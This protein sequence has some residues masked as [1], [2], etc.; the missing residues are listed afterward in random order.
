MIGT[1]GNSSLIIALLLNF[2]LLFSYSLNFF[3]KK[4][5]FQKVRYLNFLVT[6]FVFLAFILLLWSFAISDFSNTAVYQNS[7]SQKPLFY[8]ISGSWGNHEGSMVLFILILAIF[9][10]LFSFSG[11]RDNL[12]YLTIFFQNILILF[13]LIFLIFTSNPFDVI[14]PTPAEGLGLNPILQDPLLSIH[15]PFLY[16]GYVGFSIIFSFALAGLY[17]E[18][19]T[20]LWSK[21]ASLWIVIAWTFLTVGIGLGSIWAYYELG[22]GGFWFWDPVENASLVPWLASTALLHSNITSMKT[23][24][25]FSWTALLAILT[26]TTSLLG[27]FL[28]RSGIL[29]SVHAF[30][31]DPDRGLYILAVIMIISFFA[32]LIFILK[33][34]KSPMPNVL[35]FWSRGSFI[36]IN[37]CF[38]IFFLVVVMVGTLYPIFLDALFE[39]SISV[40]PNY[41]NALLAPF[42][43]VLLWFM[44]HGPL[45]EWYKFNKKSLIKAILQISFLTLVSSI[46]IFFYLKDFSLLLFL[47]VF[48]SIYLII[49]VIIDVFKQKIISKNLARNISHFGFG[50]LVFSIFINA[51]LSKEINVP[52]KVGQTIK[53]NA[54]EI[55]FKNILKS[56]G[57]NFEEIIGNFL[58]KDGTR[59]FELSPSL[60]KYL[61][62]VQ[63]TSE[64]SIKSTLF[65]DYY[66]AINLS[67]FEGDKIMIRFYH[68]PLMLWIW[69]SISLIIFGGLIRIFRKQNES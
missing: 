14:R 46:I 43:I 51:Y 53:Q 36:L 40:G 12:K 61:Q 28:V 63:V 29:N 69:I 30:A 10:S 33:F 34:P 18:E 24:K 58:I 8:K 7:H 62:P 66:L 47:G 17:L 26:F 32:F 5:N 4:N 31:N 49:A 64:T 42:V 54:I 21:Q 55:Q 6:V 16:V 13:F 41:Y 39:K 44:A 45:L 67:E 19:F 22:W 11:V 27:T 20:K 52:I 56:Q 3:K 65:G 23:E 59:A 1:F 57:K 25:F 15:P 50:I 35:I 60:R 2:Y 9:S 48:F 68:K 38:M 37:N